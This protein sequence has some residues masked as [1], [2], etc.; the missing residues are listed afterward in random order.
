M[1]SRW[2]KVLA[3]LWSNKTRT[4]LMVLTITVGV[5]SVGFVQSTGLI[6]NQDMDA[7]YLSAN[8]SEAQLYV[9]GIDDDL[10]AAAR[11]VPGVDN[12]E[13]RT[14]V[15]AQLVLPGAKKESIQFT[16]IEAPDQL[17]VDILKPADPSNASLPP[18]GDK[19]VLLDRSAQSLPIQPGDILEVELTDGKT[20]QLRFA[21]FVH[22]V[23]GFPF[24]MAGTVSGFVNKKTGEWLGAPSEYTRLH[25]SVAENQTDYQHVENVAQAVSNRLKKADIVVYV[26][27]IFNP[28]HHFAWEITQ[29]VIFIL[30]VMGWLTV[31]LSSIL[32]V[33]TINAL[34]T[35][36]TRQ[37]GIMKA[38]GGGTAQIM[39][40]YL[41][42]M[43]AF[44]GLAFAVSVPLGSWAATQNSMFMANY[45]NFDLGAPRTYPQTII[46]QAI[47]A[48]VVPLLAALYP[49]LGNIRKPV[50][51]AISDYGISNTSK[52][53][54]ATE[55][56]RIPFLTRPVLI[57]MRNAFRR[58]GRLA[59]TLSTLILAGA[60]FIGVFNLWASFDQVMD[61]VQGYFLADVNLTFTRGYRFEK[62]KAIALSVPGV[63][64][65]EGWN[66]MSGQVLSNDKET[67]NEVTFIAPPSNSTLIKP[68]I[69]DGRWLAPGDENAIV[70]G[71]HLLNVRPDLKVGDEI[72]IEI[73]G[74]ET[75][76]TIIGVY[77]LP[78]N[79]VPP[80]VYTN[81]EYLSRIIGETGLVYDL[82][83][84]TSQHD[85]AYQEQ[86]ATQLQAAF[87]A[88]KIPV[89]GVQT[90]AIWNS[91]QKSQT[92]VLVY[93]ILVMAMLIAF[94]GGLGLMGTMSVNVLER[95]REVGVM[96]SIGASNLDIQWI[97]IAEGLVIGLISWAVALLLSLPITFVLT[98]GVGMA[99]FQAELPTVFGVQGMIAWLIGILIIA[100]IASALP[101]RRA[102]RLTVRDTLVYE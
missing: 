96:R 102:S 91:Q 16:V 100:A 90:S 26:V 49:L 14:T 46:M 21:G 88:N 56:K 10:V 22:D 13:G 5:F 25:L 95:T 69:T 65:V 50:R 51:E 57:S 78:G 32:I 93:F 99:I 79:V 62:V 34:M 80:L 8:P 4:F 38:I 39:G 11:R 60:I 54:P 2:K 20:R 48:F 35:Q 15:S 77:R 30:T 6:I 31:L 23:T 61:D 98:Y 36:H 29:G 44:G 59:L 17:Q 27:A 64:S 42:L 53:R 43:L 41:V 89:A 97:V 73:N 82:R 24:H 28:G 72:I 52:Q 7:D 33:N 76:W 45:L 1:A 75:P 9:S 71:N 37:I 63:E 40:M 74:K 19:E 86:V 68:M 101:A 47:V 87:Q 3:D 84:I 18:L 55:S 12:A 67:S 81:Y 85:A 58:K 94:V 70:I 66:Y 92:D 83:V